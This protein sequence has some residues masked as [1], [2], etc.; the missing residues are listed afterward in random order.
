MNDTNFLADFFAFSAI[1]L[2]ENTE[3]PQPEKKCE[4]KEKNCNSCSQLPED[5]DKCINILKKYISD[6]EVF[7]IFLRLKCLRTKVK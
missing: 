7:E 2:M 6:T 5:I 1:M 4:C 3:K